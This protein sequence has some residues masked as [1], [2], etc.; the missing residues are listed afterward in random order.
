MTA[1]S[2]GGGS[3]TD[4]AD[5][6]GRAED[7]A[8]IVGDVTGA[9]D[10]HRVPPY[11]RGHVSPPRRPPPQGRRSSLRRP[12]RQRD[13]P[14]QARTRFPQ[15]VEGGAG[16]TPSGATVIT[17]SSWSAAGATTSASAPIGRRHPAALA[18]GASP[19]ATWIREPTGRPGGGGGRARKRARSGRSS[20]RLSVTDRAA[21]VGLELADE[22]PAQGKVR[23]GLGL[24]PR[25]LVAVLRDVGDPEPGEQPYVVGRTGLGDDDERHSSLRSRPA[26]DSAAAI[27]S[28]STRLARSR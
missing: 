27:R 21:L 19:S 13:G 6:D 16:S 5:Q 1:T 22:V 11:R 26:A 25:V 18:S 23:A 15:P 4:A 14:A 10:A 8:P 20:A 7:R 9:E 12:R 2:S 28:T 17:P 24:G 3:S